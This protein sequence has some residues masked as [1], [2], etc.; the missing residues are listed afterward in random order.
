VNAPFASS[1][2][3]SITNNVL[4]SVGITNANITITKDP[5]SPFAPN[6]GY[7]LVGFKL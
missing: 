6:Q 4:V 3:D 5:G 7:S 1:V 2:S